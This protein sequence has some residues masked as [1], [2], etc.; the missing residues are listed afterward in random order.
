MI[1]GGRRSVPLRRERQ[2]VR[3]RRLTHRFSGGRAAQHGGDRPSEE[4]AVDGP[5]AEDR[6][7]DPFRVNERAFLAACREG[8]L[9]HLPRTG[10]VTTLADPQR[11]ARLLDAAAAEA[12]DRLTY[13][14][15]PE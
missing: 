10:H 14:A 2:P 11:L 15:K 1:N 6:A 8:R 3:H 7:R 13:S 4:L 9:I 12:E 5:A